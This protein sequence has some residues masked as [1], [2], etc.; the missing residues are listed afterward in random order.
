MLSV[1]LIDR[2]LGFFSSWSFFLASA[3]NAS[4]AVSYDSFFLGSYP[5]TT[6]KPII[7]SE[8]IFLVFKE[9]TASLNVAALGTYCGKSR[10]ASERKTVFVLPDFL[11]NF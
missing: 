6:D 5:A 1:V 10:F 2:G 8:M 11:V 4:N 3:K 7:F 9:A